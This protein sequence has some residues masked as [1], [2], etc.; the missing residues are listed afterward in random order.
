MVLLDCELSGEKGTSAI[1]QVD[2]E[3]KAKYNRESNEHC[4]LA[5]LPL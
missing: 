2:N 3:E 1:I 5:K 4:W